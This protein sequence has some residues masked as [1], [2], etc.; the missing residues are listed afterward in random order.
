MPITN[1]KEGTNKGTQNKVE[2][3]STL[4]KD[5]LSYL[6]VAGLAEFVKET[7]EV[8]EAI[9]KSSERY[10]TAYIIFDEDKIEESS[11]FENKSM[12]VVGKFLAL[13]FS[14]DQKTE[15]ILKAKQTIL[16]G[17]KIFRGEKDEIKTVGLR[18]VKVPVSEVM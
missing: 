18:F 3:K 15:D 14:N 16:C 10:Q 9:G 1:K 5:A 13:W 8:T 2:E 4:V 6:E 12:Q 11:L 7:K 17:S